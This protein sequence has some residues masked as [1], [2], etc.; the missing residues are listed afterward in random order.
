MGHY[1]CQ[2]VVHNID[3]NAIASVIEWHELG[4]QKN[5]NLTM[6]M[7]SVVKTE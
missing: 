2:I 7:Y 5:E 6:A 4:W 1:N 3:G